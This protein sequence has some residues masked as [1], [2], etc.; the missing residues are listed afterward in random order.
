MIFQPSSAKASFVIPADVVRYI[1]LE[2]LM[3]LRDKAKQGLQRMQEM[4]QMGNADEVTNPDQTFASEDDDM[5]EQEIDDILAE[6]Q[7]M[8]EGF[9]RGGSVSGT[10]LT[11]AVRNPMVDVRFFRNKEGKVMFITHINGRH[12][13]LFLKDL[14]KQMKAT[15]NLSEVKQIRRQQKKNKKKLKSLSA[16]LLWVC[17]LLVIVKGEERQQDL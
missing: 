12:L 10:D 1:G 14:L 3:A 16:W 6:E 8:P 13:Y 4:G 7:P 5:F 11:K 9:A 17:R 2:K 15:S